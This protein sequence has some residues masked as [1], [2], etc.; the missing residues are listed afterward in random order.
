VLEARVQ[1]FVFEG[2]LVG[3]KKKTFRIHIEASKRQD[4]GRKIEFL[5]SPLP[6]VSRI[7]VELAQ[8][9]IGLVKSD[10]HFR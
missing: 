8:D 7:G 10:E 1:Q 2:F 6:F 3:E 9:A 5:Q 4:F